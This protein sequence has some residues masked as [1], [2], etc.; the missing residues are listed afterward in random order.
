MESIRNLEE[1]EIYFP[2]D[3]ILATPTKDEN[4]VF[5]NGGVLIELEVV[6]QSP[7]GYL[8]LRV[9]GDSRGGYATDE[10]ARPGQAFWVSHDGKNAEGKQL[11]N[12]IDTIQL[13]EVDDDDM[14][15][16]PVGSFIA[17]W[18]TLSDTTGSPEPETTQKTEQV[19]ESVGMPIFGSADL[20]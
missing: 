20:S 3:R 4:A 17:T 2:G 13:P 14:F 18:P 7:A 10:E 5:Y 1:F 19:D 11:W 16:V 6:E 8:K 12:F 9:V 15:V